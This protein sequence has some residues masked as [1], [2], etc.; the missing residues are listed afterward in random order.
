MDLKGL[1]G[2][3]Q[4]VQDPDPGCLGSQKGDPCA[5]LATGSSLSHRYLL[6]R[7]PILQGRTLR[8]P[9]RP[10]PTAVLLFGS[11]NYNLVLS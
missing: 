10:L 1:W 6:E 7:D 2:L 9:Y 4:S 5:D 11:G 8:R 3:V